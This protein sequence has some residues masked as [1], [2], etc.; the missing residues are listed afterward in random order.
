MHP[1]GFELA[2]PASVRPT[3]NII[4]LL[5][6]IVHLQF[7]PLYEKNAKI[8]DIMEMLQVAKNGKYL[9]IMRKFTCT[10]SAEKK[11]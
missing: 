4:R 3:M 2:I 6:I 1:V 9:K 7:H 5:E 10:I 8:Y 11:Q